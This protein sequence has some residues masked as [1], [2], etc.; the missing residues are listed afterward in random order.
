MPFYSCRQ[1]EESLSQNNTQLRDD[2]D[3]FTRETADVKNQMTQ[4]QDVILVLNSKM[5]GYQARNRELENEVESIKQAALEKENEMFTR[6]TAL[7][8][9][10]DTIQAENLDLV[11]KEQES[12]LRVAKGEEEVQTMLEEVGKL[13]E[14]IQVGNKKVGG[15]F[16]DF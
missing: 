1:R 15:P 9:D 3:G 13:R 7:S 2:L 6:I 5:D 4:L 11:A 8:N 14:E 16:A 10:L 12:G